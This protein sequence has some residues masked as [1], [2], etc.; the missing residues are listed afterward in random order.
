MP[1][2]APTPQGNGTPRKNGHARGPAIIG[3]T[4][5]GRTTV[6]V[7]GMNLPYCVDAREALM[8]QGELFG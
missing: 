7:L 1:S 2:G 6:A 3:L 5:I 4:S 8:P